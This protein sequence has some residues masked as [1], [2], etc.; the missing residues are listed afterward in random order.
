[1]L[2]HARISHALVA[3]LKASQKLYPHNKELQKM[4]FNKSS[5]DCYE[6]CQV[7]QFKE[8]LFRIMR[9]SAT[10]TPQIIQANLIGPITLKTYRKRYRLI[11]VFIKDHLR[12]AMAYS[13]EYKS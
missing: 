13:T 12:L 9:S 7:A 2:W 6:M 4:N 10:Q 8:L 1:M 5:I 11:S 3:Y